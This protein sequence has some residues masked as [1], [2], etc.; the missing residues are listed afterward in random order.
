VLGLRRNHGLPS[1]ADR[2]RAR[3]LLTTTEIA[4]RLGL[5]PGTITAWQRAGLLSAHKANDRNML[6]YEPPTPGDPRLAKQQGRRLDR[7]E[8]IQPRP[9]GAL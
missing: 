5:H 8:L 7:R 3:G 9:G 1:H 4:E 6:L 2:L